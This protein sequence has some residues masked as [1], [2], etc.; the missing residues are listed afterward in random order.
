[1][2]IVGKVKTKVMTT[3]ANLGARVAGKALDALESI[4]R[5]RLKAERVRAG[6]PEKLRATAKRVPLVGKRLVKDKLEPA[7]EQLREVAPKAAN[8]KA[9]P[10][11][12]TT[13]MITKPTDGKIH[14]DPVV[15]HPEYFK[16]RKVAS[17]SGRKTIPA[18]AAKRVQAVQS[19]SQPQG[20]KPKKGQKNK[21]H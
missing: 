13:R 10:R 18:A 16:G 9:E 17:G 5:A 11:R 12:T 7:M 15:K 4:D 19:K 3:G 2:G 8:K 20:F 14:L 6:A 1:M 21:H